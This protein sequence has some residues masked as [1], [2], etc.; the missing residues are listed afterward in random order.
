[1]KKNL[2]IWQ[3]AGVTFTAVFGTVLHFLFQWTDLKIFAPIS[4][5]NEST[6][7]H[8]KLL[9]IPSLFFATIQYFIY[10][11]DYKCF[12]ATKLIGILLGTLLIP[13]LFYTLSGS[14]GTL[15]AFINIAIFFVSIFLEYA[16]EYFLFDK[17][18]CKI[19]LNWVSVGVLIFVLTLFF[20]FTFYPP[21]I[22]LF[23]DPLTKGFGIVK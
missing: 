10:K 8:M 2:F 9:F 19:W 6:W 23:L 4:A 11:K 12:W 21:Q 17:I 18:N 16:I 13:T 3:I 14:F 5:I 22:P 7:E 15:S 1:M 20:V